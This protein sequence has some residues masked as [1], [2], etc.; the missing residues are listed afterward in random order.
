MKAAQSEGVPIDIFALLAEVRSYLETV[1]LFRAEG[2]APHWAADEPE[3]I[4]RAKMLDVEQSLL[5]E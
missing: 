1:A 4:N 3:R 5:G 2:Y